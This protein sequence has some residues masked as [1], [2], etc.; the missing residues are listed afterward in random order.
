MCLN[1]EHSQVSKRDFKSCDLCNSSKL[2]EREFSTFTSLLRKDFLLSWVSTWLK[3][4]GKQTMSFWEDKI[5]GKQNVVFLRGQNIWKIE[6]CLVETT[7]YLE[8]KTLCCWDDK[9]FWKQNNAKSKSWNCSDKVERSQPRGNASSFAMSHNSKSE[10]AADICRN[11][12]QR[13]KK[14]KVVRCS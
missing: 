1:F 4:F 10:K 12:I 6:R 7:K 3:I 5:F 2:A 13:T 14:K 11:W 9:I 8:N